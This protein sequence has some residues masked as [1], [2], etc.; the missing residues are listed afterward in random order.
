VEGQTT[1]EKSYTLN[2]T[3][4]LNA[5]G[6]ELSEPASSGTG[7][8][9]IYGKSFND[10]ESGEVYTYNYDAGSFLTLDYYTFSIQYNNTGVG[11]GNGGL[12]LGYFDIEESI[13]GISKIIFS[14]LDTVWV[15][16]AG[17]IFPGICGGYLSYSSGKAPDSDTSV[18]DSDFIITG[19]CILTDENGLF[20]FSAS[21]YLIGS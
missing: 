6:S 8:V 17:Q 16:P 4:T 14:P 20:E 3:G 9:A 21:F 18:I 12:Y 15:S 5:P 11:V 10:V 2:G 19:G 7:N 1:E 13:E